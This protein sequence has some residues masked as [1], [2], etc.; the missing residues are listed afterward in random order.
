[1]NI[2]LIYTIVVAALLVLG[3]ISQWWI[4]KTYPKALEAWAAH[5]NIEILEKAR[6]AWDQG[7]FTARSTQWQRVY[8]LRIQTPEKKEKIIWAKIGNPW[9]YSRHPKITLEKD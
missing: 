4:T 8:R 9:F 6:S 1:M 7:P 2:W 5:R 3:I